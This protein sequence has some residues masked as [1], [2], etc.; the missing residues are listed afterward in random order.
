MCVLPLLT[1]RMPCHGML[2]MVLPQVTK[3]AMC[4]FAMC[5]VAMHAG[6]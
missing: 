1:L 2:L 5:G 4:G 6:E 3:L